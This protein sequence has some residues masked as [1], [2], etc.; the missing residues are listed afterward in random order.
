MR[1][2]RSPAPPQA[3]PRSLSRVLISLYRAA[4]Q[5]A[6]RHFFACWGAGGKQDVPGRRVAAKGDG[7]MQPLGSGLRSAPTASRGPQAPQ[8]AATSSLPKKAASSHCPPR[9]LPG[10]CFIRTFHTAAPLSPSL[11][12]PIFAPSL[13]DR[14]LFPLIIHPTPTEHGALPQ[15]PNSRVPPVGQPSLWSSSCPVQATS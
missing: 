7:R 3:P 15:H 1:L 13:E 6:S 12:L 4:P 14:T 11:I 9:P 10:G 5:P 8:A 2:R